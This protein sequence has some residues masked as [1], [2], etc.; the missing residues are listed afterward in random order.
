MSDAQPVL[1]PAY[2]LSTFFPIERNF[3]IRS[4]MTGKR[5]AIIRVHGI[6][7][8]RRPDVVAGVAETG[9]AVRFFK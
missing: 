9:T 8:L 5:I 2:S 6:R 1:V 4:A 7:P 3:S